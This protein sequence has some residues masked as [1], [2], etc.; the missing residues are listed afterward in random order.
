LRW[1]G[2]TSSRS[3]ASPFRHKFA[4]FVSIRKEA[5]LSVPYEVYSISSMFHCKKSRDLHV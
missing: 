5:I 4:K 3:G 2:R 1:R